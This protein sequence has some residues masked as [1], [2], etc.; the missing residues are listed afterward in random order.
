MIKSVL[1]AAAL[2]FA[3]MQSNAD[4]YII[5]GK[6]LYA[7]RTAAKGAKVTI[8][9]PED[10]LA[11]KKDVIVSDD[12]SY[13]IAIGGSLE[14]I[15]LIDIIAEKSG[16]TPDTLHKVINSSIVL[17]DIFLTPLNTTIYKPYLNLIA[18]SDAGNNLVAWERDKNRDIDYYIIKRQN[19][20]G[21]FDS[22]GKV[23][24][25]AMYSLFEDTDAKIKQN[26]F[27]QIEAVFTNK[28]RSLPSNTRKTF[29]LTLNSSSLTKSVLLKFDMAVFTGLDY[30]AEEVSTVQLLKSSDGKRF[31]AI[32]EK[33]LAD[34]T[35]NDV[36]ELLPSDTIS[37]A[38]TYYYRVVVN[39]KDTV[40]PS[41]L[42][43]DSGPFSQSMSNL[44]EAIIEGSD[45]GEDPMDPTNSPVRKLND[46]GIARVYPVP[47]SGTFT[48]ESTG[49]SRLVVS[50]LTGETVLD[51]P[52]DTRLTVSDSRI[53]P[54]TYHVAVICGG[55]TKAF[56][57]VIK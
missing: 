7:D 12:G 4:P 6:V 45:I 54:G 25:D 50:S 40:F 48:V 44:A 29:E 38:G 28:T 51:L 9:A 18:Q 31:A 57:Q 55:E 26:Q 13:Q 8:S 35:Y 34:I 20:D 1:T 17:E 36:M 33:R 10:A 47:T 43:S 41:A 15:R 56:L 30:P 16:Y 24:Y 22:I 19:A 21:I 46:F 52:F 39:Y 2:V 37:K 3:V 5:K 32:G 14:Y 53:I 49:A 27:Y 42:K 11:Q 23:E